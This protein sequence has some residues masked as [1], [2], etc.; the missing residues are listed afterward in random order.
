MRGPDAMT[1]LTPAITV[2]GQVQALRAGCTLADLIDA[3]GHGPASVATALN[4]QFVARSQRD[5]RVL[6][7]GDQVSCFQAIVGG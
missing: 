4:G 5:A 2:N 1:E 6:C 7:D 3:L